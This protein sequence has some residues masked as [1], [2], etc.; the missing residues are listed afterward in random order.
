MSELCTTEEMIERIKDIISTKVGDRKV[1]DSDVAD[2]LGV[3][4]INLYTMKKRN[5]LPLREVI[6]LCDRC[7]LDPLK[8]VMKSC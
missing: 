5:R 2:L 8:I 1:F 3:S 6:L 4:R 7:G